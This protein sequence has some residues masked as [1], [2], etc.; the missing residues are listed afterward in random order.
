MEARGLTARQVNLF[1]ERFTERF[2]TILMLMNGSGTIWA[3]HMYNG[4]YRIKLDDDLHRI[5]DLEHILFCRDASS[6]IA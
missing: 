3:S 1:D 4:L 5:K 2:D 6:I